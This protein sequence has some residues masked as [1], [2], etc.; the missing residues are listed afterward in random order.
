LKDFV[1][2][3]DAYWLLNKKKRPSAL[4]VSLSAWQPFLGRW[5]SV[6]GYSINE[7]P[8]GL[9]QT[10]I[11]VVKLLSENL[12]LFEDTTRFP[13]KPYCSDS[14]GAHCIRTLQKALLKP[15][16]QINPPHLRVWSIF[17]ID[18]PRAAL[19]WEDANLPAPAWA[20]VD[21]VTTKGHLVWG[22][23]VP[24]LVNAPDMRIA[25]L[26]YLCAV[27]SAFKSKLNADMGFSGLITKN[28]AHDQ[29]RV[30]R[31]SRHNYDLAELA[32]WVD[33]PKHLPKRKPEQVGLGRNITVF[34]W[35]RQYAYRNIRS[36]KTDVKNYVLWQS[37]LNNKALERN[38]DFTNPLQGNEVWH[39]SK[40]ISKW[41]WNRFDIA[42]SDRK[43]SQI[44]AHRGRLG[45][46]AKG[47]ANE[48]KRASARLMAISG[49]S[50]KSIADALEVDAR[51]I[52]RWISDF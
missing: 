33:L 5:C 15:Y 43:F 19:A 27:E 44:Q 51:T 38:G 34:E 50:Q 2:A 36:Y 4:T 30:L 45:G 12:D 41:T 9:L 52:R 25:P 48:E 14:K 29:W 40:S 10:K 1:T 46:I 35:L 39:I 22:L 42:Q 16:I 13:R 26:R 31:G 8:T 20:A 24:V 23:S 49:R 11:G 21:K 17:D 47:L 3:Y 7:N 28:P 32:E 6:I 37:H 18:R